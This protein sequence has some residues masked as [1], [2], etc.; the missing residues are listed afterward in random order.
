MATATYSL[1]ACRQGCVMPFSIVEGPDA[2]TASDF[3][4]VADHML[5]LTPT[6][7]A[8]LDAAVGSVLS[9]GKRLQV[10]GGDG[11]GN[12]EWTGA[13]LACGF[14]YVMMMIMIIVMMIMM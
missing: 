2:W 11:G 12:R 14:L 8:E 6:H 10:W 13:W 4:V 1:R 3:P 9:S 5:H 7:L